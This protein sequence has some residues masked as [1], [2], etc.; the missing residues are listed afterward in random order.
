MEEPKVTIN[1]VSVIGATGERGTIDMQGKEELAFADNPFSLITLRIEFQAFGVTTGK[2]IVRIH[3]GDDIIKDTEPRELE[4]RGVMP[5]PEYIHDVSFPS[6]GVYELQFFFK[7]V[8]VEQRFE[9]Q[10]KRLTLT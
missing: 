4:T 5:I 3:Q 1:S 6:P 8:P 7:D 2:M 9:R 10:P